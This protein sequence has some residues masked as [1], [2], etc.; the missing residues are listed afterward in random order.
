MGVISHTI[1][2]IKKWLDNELLQQ[3][4]SWM[5]AKKPVTSSWWHRCWF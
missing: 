2:D 4:R 5:G 1:T 3:T